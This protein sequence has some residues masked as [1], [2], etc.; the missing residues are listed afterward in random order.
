MKA[1]LTFPS[2]AV[3]T[4]GVGATH[5]Q[6]TGSEAELHLVGNQSSNSSSNSSNGVHTRV[7]TYRSDDRGRRYYERRI[8]RRVDPPPRWRRGRGFDDD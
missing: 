8:Y 3:L 4:L 5:A 2:L 6:T 1:W 7:D